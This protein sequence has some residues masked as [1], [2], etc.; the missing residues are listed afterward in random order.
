MRADYCHCS[1]VV[2]TLTCYH[3]VMLEDNVT[4]C[5]E[6]IVFLELQYF[7]PELLGGNFV[8]IEIPGRLLFD[9]QFYTKCAAR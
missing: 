9:V 2:Y 3:Y 6:M 8:G 4:S 1:A 7:L 5:H